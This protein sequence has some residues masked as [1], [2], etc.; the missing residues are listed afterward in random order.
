MDEI[1]EQDF[2][3]W[4]SENINSE[5][6]DEGEWLRKLSAPWIGNN[7]T[8]DMKQLMFNNADKN[9]KT[10]KS[11][12]GIVGYSTPYDVVIHIIN[13]INATGRERDIFLPNNSY[14]GML[15]KRLDGGKKSRRKRN[16]TGSRRER[17]LTNR[18][19]EPKRPLRGRRG[20][21]RRTSRSRCCKT[22]QK[23]YRRTQG[24]RPRS[25]NE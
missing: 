25:P 8:N 4:M 5:N 17:A 10:W 22:T 9:F 6:F 11:K 14:D 1:Q 12:N 21:A 3:G 23:R 7:R 19:G 15:S 16:W 24:S 18:N 20:R 2:R 13:F